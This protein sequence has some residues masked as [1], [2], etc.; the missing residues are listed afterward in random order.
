[1]AI[2]REDGDSLA[3]VTIA[4]EALPA[5]AQL[6]AF[7]WP[8]SDTTL[9]PPD[10]GGDGWIAAPPNTG[11]VVFTLADA[12]HAWLALRLEAGEGGAPVLGRAR[13]ESGLEAWLYDLPPVYARDDDA[14]P[15]LERLLAA[16]RAGYG[17]QE[18]RID[19]LP[20]LFG[21]DT[22]VDEAPKAAWLDWLAGC[23]A[24]PLGDVRRPVRRHAVAKAFSLNRRR[25]TAA[26]LRETIDLVLGAQ[27]WISEPAQ[28][29]G[30]WML[31]GEN[32]LGFDTAL[33]AAEAQGAVVGTTATLDFSHLTRDGDFGAPLFDDLAHHF[34]VGV[35]A[36][37]V[38]TSEARAA[39]SRLVER[40]R[41]AHTTAHICVVEPR[42]RLGFQARVGIDAIVAGAAPALRLGSGALGDALTTSTQRP[43]PAAGLTR[44]GERGG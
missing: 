35:Y 25:G 2:P 37:E 13:I 20:L 39:L 5:G 18:Q 44:I 43:A 30:L 7:A 14:R 32:S 23:L 3:G 33:A 6:R 21:A 29:A 26:G 31:D 9:E 16:L 24:F 8:C 11:E 42:A 41:P 1:V 4:I 28:R 17:E 27:S 34:C 15:F 40:E 19:D 38:E 36:A 22:A 12:S 10:L